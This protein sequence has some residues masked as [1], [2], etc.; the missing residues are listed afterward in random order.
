[1]NGLWTMKQITV[2]GREGEREN[3]GERKK[4][5]GKRDSLLISIPSND[6]WPPTG[7]LYSKKKNRETKKNVFYATTCLRGTLCMHTVSSG[8]YGKLNVCM[9]HRQHML[10]AF[11]GYKISRWSTSRIESSKKRKKHT[12]FT[13]WRTHQASLHLFFFFLI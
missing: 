6:D 2:K 3:E 4:W 12:M 13:L 5:V 10:L 11:F 1:M 7:R 9:W 8:P